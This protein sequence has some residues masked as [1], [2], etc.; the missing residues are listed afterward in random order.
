MSRRVE[1]GTP[2]PKVGGSNP[3][4]HAISNSIKISVAAVEDA[5]NDLM[6]DLRKTGIEERPFFPWLH[7]ADET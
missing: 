6:G 4:R 2:D 1:K 7:S 5:L 3:L